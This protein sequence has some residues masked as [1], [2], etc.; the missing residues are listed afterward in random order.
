MKSI[1]SIVYFICLIFLII[2]FLNISIGNIN[3]VIELNGLDFAFDELY[4]MVVFHGLFIEPIIILI[5][6]LGFAVRKRIGFVLAMVYPYYIITL[7][8]L[9][10]FELPN[11]FGAINLPVI[12]YAIFIL[13]G[14][15]YTRTT[16]VLVKSPDFRFRLYGN[17]ISLAIGLTMNIALANSYL[18]N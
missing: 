15:N 17:L 10:I 8:L 16:Q 6:I 5:S 13:V 4:P 2:K 11:Y 1:G 12:S 3:A 7:T 18:I 9:E 14:A